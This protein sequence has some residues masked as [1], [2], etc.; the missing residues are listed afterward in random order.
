M[1]RQLENLSE[2][3]FDLVVVGGGVY[4]AAIA[5]DG[6]LRGLSVALV[7]RDDFGSGTSFNN[8]KTVHGGLRYLQHADFRRMRESIRERSILM[9]IAPHLVHP[10]PFGVPTYRDFL[11]SRAA[12]GLA[13]LL[14]DLVSWDRNRNGDPTQRIPGSRLISRE[15][16]LELAPGIPREGLTGAAVWYDCHMHNSDRMTLAFV[17]SAVEAGA[18]AANHL[19]VIGFLRHGE[20]VRG[21]RA[22]DALGGDEIEIR[23][24]VVVNAAGPWVDRVL[25]LL[26]SRPRPPLFIPSK[27]M[28]LITRPLLAGTALGLSSPKAG[29]DRDAWI[30]K[31]W[32][33]I[34][35]IPWR[36][37]SLIGTR[38]SRFAGEPDDLESKEQDIEGFLA[39]INQAYPAAKLQREDV[40]LVHR[41]L[42]PMA[43]N[44]SS[45]DEVRLLKQYRIEDHRREGIRGL[46]TV[47]GVKY[48]TARDVAEKT[49]S[50]VFTLLER[51][52]PRSRSRD[53]R[54]YG[55]NVERFAD[56]M[57][58]EASRRPYGL[59]PEV[60][61][62]LVRS[63]GS[64]YPEVLRAIEDGRQWAEPV[65]E[66]SLVIKAEIRYAVREEMALKLSSAVLR[67]TELGS[68]GHPGRKGLETA[69]EL[70][71]AELGWSAARREQEIDEVES[72]YRR[73]S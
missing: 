15:Q 67:R 6:S 31:G 38:H 32:R 44:P 7:E 69:A 72:F 62:H 24:R 42:L 68:A 18:V 45:G 16:C 29:R 19:E 34:A 66:G 4:G 51:S 56:F 50:R 28:N 46:L 71:G 48:T 12:L 65:R 27:A 58:S 53:T 40:R 17:R 30:E 52:P 37:S 54:L 21:V 64:A 1:R 14:N 47:V 41:G 2:R 3:E 9:R 55:G 10:L 20:R 57:E 23:A 8:A 60:V 39:E 13:L 59:S 70:M 63:Y 11:R 61:R 49:V 5:W 35:V 22:R 25:R 36:E 73:R 43:A 26:D 33:F